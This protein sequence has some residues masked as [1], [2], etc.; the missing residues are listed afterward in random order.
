M[1]KKITNQD[2]DKSTKNNF[3]DLNNAD[4]RS[5]NQAYNLGV[6]N[7]V[8]DTKFDP[9][10]AITREQAA[11]ILARL[12]KV[13]G[14]PLPDAGANPFTDNISAWA[15]SSVVSC[16]AA[17]IMTGV[18]ETKFAPKDTYSDQQALVSLYRLYNYVKS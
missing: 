11:T 2:V 5:I 10:G 14:K 1:Y 18:S 7:G 8:S 3:T 12:A 17:K 13:C 16:N 6:I 15:Q 4:Y 9:K